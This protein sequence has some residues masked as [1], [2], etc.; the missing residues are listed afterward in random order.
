VVVLALG[1]SDCEALRDGLLGQPVN[2][3]SSLA[4]V[5]AGA[6]VL[7]RGGPTAPAWALGAVGLGSVLYHGPMPPGA[8][9]VHDGAIVALVAAVCVL[10]WRRRSFVRPPT[11]ALVALAAGGAVNVLTR[12]GAALCRPDSLLQG[13]AAWHALTALGVAVWLGSGSSRHDLSHGSPEGDSGRPRATV[14]SRWPDRPS[15][16]RD[17]LLPR[18]LPQASNASGGGQAHTRLRSP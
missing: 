8:E 15:P 5:A 9:A 10:A 13:H 14:A 7:R 3:L 11:L 12:T 18:P 2:S 1:A 16:P 17:D 4:Y 6:Y